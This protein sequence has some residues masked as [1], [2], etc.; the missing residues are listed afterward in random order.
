MAILNSADSA[1]SKTSSGAPGTGEHVLLDLLR[2]AQ[3]RTHPRVL[4][5]DP[6][7]VRRVRRQRHLERE[8]VDV[9]LAADF[10]IWPLRVSSSH[11]VSA[12]T[13]SDLLL[14]GDIAA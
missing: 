5:D 7:V 3:E 9:L 2:G 12:S 14:E 1:D 10:R 6:R 4:L 8:R 13:G 11:T